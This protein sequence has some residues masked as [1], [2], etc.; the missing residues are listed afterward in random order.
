MLWIKIYTQFFYKGQST[1]VDVKISQKF[2][3]Q[4]ISNS[5]NYGSDQYVIEREHEI[6]KATVMLGRNWQLIRVILEGYIQK[7]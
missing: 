7:N 5:K 4:L 2:Y 3:G 1:R 6:E